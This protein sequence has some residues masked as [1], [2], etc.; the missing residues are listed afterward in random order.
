MIIKCST[1]QVYNNGEHVENENAFRGHKTTGVDIE[2]FRVKKKW[3]V[4][5]VKGPRKGNVWG[6]FGSKAVTHIN[7]I[8]YGF[9]FF[10]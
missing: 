10:Y 9:V 6:Y 1:V 4:T 7:I 5:F 8:I 2:I 3:S